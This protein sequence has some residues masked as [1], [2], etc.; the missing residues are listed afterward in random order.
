[1]RIAVL[2]ICTGVYNQFF[3]GFYQSAHQ[4][5]FKGT[6]DVE[7]FVFTDDKELSSAPDVH[8]FEKKFEGF[9]KDSLFRFDMFLSIGER[10]QPFDYLFFF[11][12]NMLF[13]APVGEEILPKDEKLAAVLHPG[14][15]NKP[16]FLYPYERN[17]QSTAYIPP[18]SNDYHYYMGSLNGG[19]TADFLELARVCSENI[20]KD[21][22]QGIVAIFH[23]E[24]HLNR[25]FRA[26]PCKGLLPCF[27]YPEGSKLPFS[28]K[29]IIRDKEK[30][31]TYFKKGRDYTLSGR[32]KHG[33]SI[34]RRAIG[35]YI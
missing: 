1:M 15:Y 32:M 7:Y 35:W 9:P 16:A 10:L 8:L 19:K 33:L 30:I 31:A 11:N 27:A 22:D 26:H 29:I 5:F 17:K 12:A 23:D 20:H 4:F 34:L 6:A 25:Y 3:S 2:Y 13:V 18:L 14:Y 21:Y 28:P 24:S